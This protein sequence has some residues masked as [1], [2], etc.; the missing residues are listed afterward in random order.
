MADLQIV[1]EIIREKIF[2][3][4]NKEIP[5][6]TRQENV[7]FTPCK[8]GDLRIDQVVYVT[9]NAHKVRKFFFAIRPSTPDLAQLIQ[10][11]IIMLENSRWYWSICDSGYIT[12]STRRFIKIFRQESSLVFDCQDPRANAKSAVRMYVV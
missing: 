9:K 12:R 5:Y 11:L 2:K 6:Q 4:T 1:E 7:G 8:N 3:R 10:L